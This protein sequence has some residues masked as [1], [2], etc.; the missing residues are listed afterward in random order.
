MDDGL[1]G[2]LMFL[3]I[4]VASFVINKRKEMLA[5]AEEVPLPGGDVVENRPKPRSRVAKN[6]KTS[7]MAKRATTT[8]PPTSDFIGRNNYQKDEL[9]AAT[10]E[11]GDRSPYAFDS[12][13]D[14]K[15]AFIWSEI[16]KRKY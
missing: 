7:K 10:V 16:L 11:H 4:M 12:L 6:A 5:E 15:K 9:H 3:G 8:P 1:F 13:D 14:V 2:F